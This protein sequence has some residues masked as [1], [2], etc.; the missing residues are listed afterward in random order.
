VQAL[1]QD[2]KLSAALQDVL[3]RE[4]VTA[5]LAVRRAE[6]ERNPGVNELLFR[7]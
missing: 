5:Y 6:A 4:L 2:V 7:Y 3:G 1:E